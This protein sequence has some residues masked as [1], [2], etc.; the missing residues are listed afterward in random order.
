MSQPT[1]RS[2]LFELAIRRIAR[3]IGVPDS[4]LEMFRAANELSGLDRKTLPTELI[5]LNTLQ[6]ARGL[7]N[8]TLLQSL[9]GWVLPYWAER[10]YDPADP[11]FVPRSHLGL[12]INVTSRNWSAVGS[13]ECRTEP[14]VDPRGSV[15]V[16]RDQWTI[17]CWL[18]TGATTVF[19]SR[20][21]AVTQRL[22]GGLP[23][24]ITACDV[25]GLT[26]EQTV[27][28]SA[29]MLIHE[30]AVVNPGPLA[31]ECR[32]AFAV[33]PFN[34]EGATLLRSIRFERATNA[35]V[36]NGRERFTLSESPA[37]VHCSTLKAGDSAHNFQCK[38][39]APAHEEA[40]CEAGMANAYA[41]FSLSLAPGERRLISGR[42]ALDGADPHAG[43]VRSAAAAWE[44]LL[45]RGT[46][47]IVPDEKVNLLCRSALCTLLLLADGDEITPGPWTYHQFW[48]RD[49]AIMLRALDAFGFHQAVDDVIR[50]FPSRQDRSGYFR[51]Q[52]G[53]WDSNG[54]ALWAV[55]QHALLS[56]QE[57]VSDEMMDCLLK[58][59]EWIRRARLKGPPDGSCTGLLPAGL[60]AEHLG[61]ADHYFWDNWWSCAGLEALLRLCLGAGLLSE[62]SRL[63]SLLT[64]YRASVERA[65]AKV[66]REK[67]IEEIPAGPARALDCGMV[68]SCAPWYP[69]QEYGPQDQ[70]MRR[71][72]MKLMAC[73]CRD[74]LFFQNFIHSGKNPYLTLQIAHAWL[75]CGERQLFWRM[76]S[77]VVRH[78][79]PT[80]N[81]PEAIHPLTGGGSMG[82]GHHGWAAAE[83][84]LGLRGAF[85]EEV[86]K[87]GDERAELE[88]LGGIPPE[89]LSPGTSCA[90]R[91]APV[92]GGIISVET[93]SE[94]KALRVEIHFDEIRGSRA[95]AWTL[96]VPLSPSR[97][98]VNGAAAPSIS[99]RSGETLI[100]LRA[101]AGTTRVLIEH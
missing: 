47:I 23:I 71:T 42:S 90:L 68:G 75:Y 85:V 11:A 84:A 69:L 45:A 63:E 92:P 13:P 34:G 50:T 2:H 54:Q 59:A 36:M 35:F 51:S 4:A 53:E 98:T 1:L 19:P 39:T 64:A 91:R 79:S 37:L 60:S 9:D 18:Q 77:D 22:S 96:K 87:P 17:D 57:K 20:L 7:L 29:Q 58:G 43:S 100:T 48:F 33:R 86:W 8:F 12:S 101:E 61:L 28:V 5:P 76:F 82:D 99:T 21:S 55:W 32:L 97:I 83:I 31:R 67:G 44:S 49:A 56:H 10:Q 14:V 3:A 15:M 88:I 25:E 70:R 26:L 80:L 30:T 27:C 24:V 74:G 66:Q 6:L 52:L 93:E 89:W 73:Y 81:Y 94:E 95:R 41:S 62:A 40:V 16:L 72:L 65:I 46:Q 38:A 78:A